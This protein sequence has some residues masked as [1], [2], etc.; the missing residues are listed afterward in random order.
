MKSRAKAEIGAV[1]TRFFTFGNKK[2]DALKL[3]CGATL[4]PVTLAYEMYGE[5]N[6][7]RD[8]A[9]LVFHALSGSQHAAGYNYAVPGVEKLWTDECQVGWWDEFI[10][11]KKAL[12]TTRFCVICANYIG[13]C[14]GS[15]GPSSIAPKTK[16]PYGSLFPRI[17][18]SDIV[19]S[20]I[21]LLDHLK[22]QKLH[23][24]IGGSIGGL[25]CVNLA[26]RHP[27]RVS[28]VIPIASGLE[29]TKLQRIH[30]FE[31]IYAI[32]CDP[33]FCGGDYYD[34]EKP[35]LGLAHARMISHKTF[36]SLKALQQRART[37]V[38]QPCESEF[39][40]YQLT[41]PLESYML[42]Q[43]RKF[44]QRFDANTYLRIADCWQRFNLL[45]G[46]GEKKLE[47][48]F[49]RCRHQQFLIFSIS[50]DVCFYTDEQAKMEAVLK[51][52][53]ISP[54]HITVHS[55][56]GHDSFLLEPEL[57]TPH[58]VYALEGKLP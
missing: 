28:L 46:T 21:R 36:I 19:D 27:E 40:W 49:M 37:E 10:G 11:P 31:Q 48:L 18:I 3:R 47:D 26:V 33:N 4:A 7:A 14:Y 39:S 6:K 22:I 35:N 13:G 38:V 50:S 23:A 44:V 55:D 45:E 8:N 2:S 15:T 20:Q 1:E 12:D 32:E 5:L 29:T 58:L 30:T 9:I 34:G 43:G 41:S 57:Y 56:K 16:K 25:M 52:A 51:R 53:G 42:H 54:M 17:A 24:V